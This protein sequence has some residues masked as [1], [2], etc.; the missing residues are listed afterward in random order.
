[1]SRLLTLS[2]FSSHIFVL[3]PLLCLPPPSS[4]CWPCRCLHLAC[5]FVSTLH[6]LAAWHPQRLLP[7]PVLSPLSRLCP[8][9][10]CTISHI[11]CASLDFHDS[12][13]MANRFCRYSGW[14]GTSDGVS[15]PLPVPPDLDFM[16]T[17][18]HVAAPSDPL[19]PTL[20]APV[21]MANGTSAGQPLG[22]S[23]PFHRSLHPLQPQRFHLSSQPWFAPPFFSCHS[24]PSSES[25]PSPRF[26]GPGFQSPFPSSP[27][28]CCAPCLHAPTMPP[29][30]RLGIV[31]H[32]ASS[33][34]WS[35]DDQGFS[36]CE[37]SESSASS[38]MPILLPHTHISAVVC[39]LFIPTSR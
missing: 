26:P 37:V 2:P 16:D 35:W 32:H 7:A 31:L 15:T 1:M 28:V 19:S 12:R 17:G 6:G 33:P 3:P 38:L 24:S 5:F 18:A 22:W 11:S 39:T 30:P 4:P 21:S 29:L 36:I 23:P 34:C 13:P 10:P 27:P 20:Q 14:R 9:V 25:F 8:P